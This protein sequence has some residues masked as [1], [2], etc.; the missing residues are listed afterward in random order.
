MLLSRRSEVNLDDP[1]KCAQSF[2]GVPTPKSI[3]ATT[4]EPTV[5][6]P[7]PSALEMQFR[8][9]TDI[10]NV[11]GSEGS[12]RR[13]NGMCIERVQHSGYCGHRLMPNLS[14]NHA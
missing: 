1:R 7:P 8:Y 4:Y 12:G 9:R 10:Q 2:F 5:A 11:H 6:S 3:W 13:E 14:D